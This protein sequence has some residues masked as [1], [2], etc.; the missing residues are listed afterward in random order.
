MCGALAPPPTCA[1]VTCSGTVLSDR[2]PFCNDNCPT[3]TIKSGHRRIGIALSA[4][5][6][7]QDCSGHKRQRSVRGHS[8]KFLDSPF[9][10]IQYYKRQTE[11]HALHRL[12]LSQPSHSNN[13]PTVPASNAGSSNKF[14]SPQKLPACCGPHPVG[15]GGRFLW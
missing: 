8:Y 14:L 7:C 9:T 5:L 1:F 2:W 6:L 4:G 13:A 12:E 10:A 3:R 11:G 15:T